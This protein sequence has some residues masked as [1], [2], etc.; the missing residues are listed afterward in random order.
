MTERRVNL[1]TWI[2]SDKAAGIALSDRQIAERAHRIQEE[3]L[4]AAAPYLR[5]MSDLKHL[6]SKRYARTPEGG[7]AGP[8]ILWQPEWKEIYDQAEEMVN[9][10]R[11]EYIAKAG[12]AA[13]STG[14]GA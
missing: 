10:L 5:I 14:G 7:Y 4:A 11:E 9:R 6:Q 8:E 2:K 3:F 1:D 12:A 13:G